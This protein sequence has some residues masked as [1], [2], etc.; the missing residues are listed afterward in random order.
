MRRA[1]DERS[2]DAGSSAAKVA[3]AAEEL[4]APLRQLLCAAT[5]AIDRLRYARSLELYERALAAAEAL[6]LPHDSLVLAYCLSRV[7]AARTIFCE[8]GFLAVNTPQMKEVLRTVYSKDERAVSLAQRC[9]ALYHARWRAGT[10]FTPSPE[11][12]AHLLTLRQSPACA[13]DHYIDCAEDAVCYWPP[14]RTPAD[15]DARLYG[16]CGALQMTLAIHARD[17]S[18]LS[19]D[20]VLLTG[21]RL[22]LAGLREEDAAVGTLHRLQATC[23]LSAADLTALSALAMRSDPDAAAGIT[24]AGIAGMRRLA[25]ADVARHGL[26]RCA[27]P[28]CGATEPHPKCYKLCGRCRGV[29]YCSAAHS[30]EDWKRHKREEGCHAAAS[31]C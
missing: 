10:L 16:V 15:E 4:M 11:E 19:A 3:A 12:L 6:P 22:V 31:G 17:D 13:A 7:V 21:L 8:G 23:G 2:A 27:L 1:R 20:S 18:Q 28:S 29:A 26:R 9:L 25:A 24:A 5:D 14:L 30:V